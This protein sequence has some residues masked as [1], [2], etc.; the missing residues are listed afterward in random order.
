MVESGS[1][2]MD[3][4]NVFYLS[5]AKDLII[6]SCHISKIRPQALLVHAFL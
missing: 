5:T 2:A 1:S 6:S 3:R 4:D